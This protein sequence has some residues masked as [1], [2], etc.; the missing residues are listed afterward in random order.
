[1]PG[2]TCA[3]SAICG[4]H[5]GDT[6]LVTSISRTPASCRRFTR[7]IF[8][9]AGTASFS[10]CSPSRGP[11]STSL[12]LPGSFISCLSPSPSGSGVAPSPSG[13][14]LGWGHP[15]IDGLVSPLH[16]NHTG[17]GLSPLQGANLPGDLRDA[18]TPQGARRGVR[19][20]RDL[21]V[22]PERMLRRQRLAAKDVERRAGQMP[23]V[24]ER[25]QGFVHQMR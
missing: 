15:P 10:F 24:E 14:G 5:L 2:I 17:D 12:T 4:T 13:G 11:T 20:Q 23:A 7:P 18:L 9:S 19:R 6:K 22:P 1:M 16:V 8:T 25:D 21:R 3:L